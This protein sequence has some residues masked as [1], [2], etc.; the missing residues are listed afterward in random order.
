M[1]DFDNERVYDA[2]RSLPMP[3]SPADVRAAAE[4]SRGWRAVP[5]RSEPVKITLVN[6]LVANLVRR[7]LH[8]SLA[9]ALEGFKLTA[10][11]TF[12]LISSGVLGSLAEEGCTETFSVF[13]DHFMKNF[14]FCRTSPDDIQ[15]L[16]AVYSAG[17]IP[18]P[19]IVPTVKT[20]LEMGGRHAPQSVMRQIAIASN[21]LE[22]AAVAGH[23]RI[24][25]KL[26]ATDQHGTGCFTGNDVSKLDLMRKVCV[27]GRLDM[28]KHLAEHYGF[29]TQEGFSSTWYSTTPYSKVLEEV[30]ASKAPGADEVEGWLRTL[31]ESR[32]DAVQQ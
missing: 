4:A 25:A 22:R 3:P 32:D 9:E 6:Y 7:D 10:R 1:A 21:L 26:T 23:V 15:T 13:V 5:E 2:I 20:V 27:A 19:E 28:A 31:P 11:D 14:D 8:E 24:F 12:H 16:A 29:G 30:R 17:N 18:F